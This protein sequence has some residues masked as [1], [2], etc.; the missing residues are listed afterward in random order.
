VAGPV[1]DTLWFDVRRGSVQ[2][3]VASIQ[4]TGTGGATGSPTVPSG[5][6]SLVRLMPK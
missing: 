3:S 2:G 6:R 5:L 1:N 4:L